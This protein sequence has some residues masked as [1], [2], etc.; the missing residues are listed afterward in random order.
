MITVA[1]AKNIIDNNKIS[2]RIENI[3]VENS[4]ERILAENIFSPLSSP[5]F[6]NSAMDG[7]AVKWSDVEDFGLNSIELRVCGESRAGSQFKGTLNSGEAIKISTGAMLPS[8]ADTI[9]PVEDTETESNKVIVKYAKAK[10]Q[11]VRFKGEEFETGK[12]L[13]EKGSKID[14]PKLALLVSM[15][16]ENV[17]VFSKIRVAIITTGT[18]LIKLGKK[19]EESQIYDSNTIMLKSAVKLSGGITDYCL[20]AKDNLEETVEAI[21]EIRDKVDIILFSGGVSVGPHDHVKDA[22][23]KA[24]FK[25]LFWKVHQKPGKPLFMAIR[26]NTLLFGLPG[27]PVSALMCY[28]FYVHPVIIGFENNAGLLKT[29]NVRSKDPVNNEVPRDHFMRVKLIDEKKY[30]ELLEKQ[31]SNMLTSMSE[32]DGFILLRENESLEKDKKYKVYLFPWSY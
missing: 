4:L 24:G 20:S 21:L 12:L 31:G 6:T 25:K 15:G 16:I 17:K 32:A 19:K 13:L 28:T 29:M 3:T 23:D 22:A 8:S 2:S 14:P 10:N 5:L 26:G 7:F 9:I 1:E 11:H 30:F 27:N 18:E